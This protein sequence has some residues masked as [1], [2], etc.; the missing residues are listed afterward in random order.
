MA[1]KHHSGKDAKKN[2][3]KLE[4][5]IK[6]VFGLSNSDNPDLSKSAIVFVEKIDEILDKSKEQKGRILNQMSAL[7][8]YS[9]VKK[10]YETFLSNV[11]N[12]ISYL[13]D[14]KNKL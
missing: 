1:D 13:N 12:Y 11:D 10:E 5:D 6:N 8:K 9:P 3:K 14:T 7:D 2:Q 4:E